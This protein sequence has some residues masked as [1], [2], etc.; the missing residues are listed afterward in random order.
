MG[1]CACLHVV[2]YMKFIQML[3]KGYYQC[4]WTW[5][6]LLES[7]SVL[8]KWVTT[9]NSHWVSSGWAEGMFGSESKTT[10]VKV[11]VAQSCLTL[12]SPMDCIVHRILQCRT[13]EWVAFP[14][15]RGS[16]QSRDQT[17]TSRIAGGFFTSWVT[18]KAQEY[19]SEQPIPSPGE[20]PDAG[21]KLGSPALQADSL[22]TELPGKPL[23]RL[24]GKGVIHDIFKSVGVRRKNED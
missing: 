17:Q 16:S 18:K 24:V 12:C 15:S 20:H 13:L 23:Q 22:P 21:I 8:D 7:G 19:W 3:H 11:K 4:Y 10:E 6:C 9:W 1:R 14:I 2:L 5:A